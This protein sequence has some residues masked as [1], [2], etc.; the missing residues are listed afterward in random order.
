MRG[1]AKCLGLVSR[2]GFEEYC[3]KYA[4]HFKMGCRN[5]ILHVQTGRVAAPR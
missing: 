2:F 5:G 1:R 4:K 3:E